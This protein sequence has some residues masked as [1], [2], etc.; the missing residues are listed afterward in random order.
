MRHQAAHDRVQRGDGHRLRPGRADHRR[1]LDHRVVGQERQRA[2][3]VQVHHLDVPGAEG[4]RGEQRDR[5]LGV[6][7][8]AAL[9]EH[10]RLVRE[11]R[12]GVRGQQ[13]PLDPRD[14]LRAGRLVALP[15]HGGVVRPEIVQVGRW[16]RTGVM[17]Y[18]RRQPGVVRD[19][20]AVL[21]NQVGQH[22]R[23]VHHGRPFPG[24]VVQA[25][26]VEH[27]P[28]GI[29]A[30][31]GG[32]VPLEP[33][34]HVAQPDRP[35]ARVEQCPGDDPDRVG[36]IDDPCGV[37]GT[38]ARS[39]SNVEH[40]RNG[41]E[42][43]RKPAGAGGLLADAAVLQRPGLVAVP[44]RLAAD[45]Q[46]QEHRAGAVQALVEAGGPGQPAWVTV[47]AHEPVGE[48]ADDRQPGLVRVDQDQFFDGHVAGQP[49]D[50][51]H[52]LG[53]VRGPAADDRELHAATP[54]CAEGATAP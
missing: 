25:D 8:P 1:H 15:L 23:A 46:L 19:F 2:P 5:R 35:V 20:L 40:Y 16:H 33:D 36:E 6:E 52:K 11:R 3:V 9:A 28:G 49:G 41:T 13:F 4:E 7:R 32:E 42:S 50:A 26:V 12:V 38:L 17:Q 22:V 39:F 53:R 43:F 18:G 30:E 27:H 48:R 24:Q 31:Q 14:L 37:Q 45:P 29:D 10:L 34:R 44:R 54:R 21:G 47:G 51:V